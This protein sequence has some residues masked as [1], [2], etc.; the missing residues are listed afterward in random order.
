VG[1][2]RGEAWEHAPW[3]TTDPEVYKALKGFAEENK[4]N[5]TTAEIKLWKCLKNKQLGGQKFRRQHIIDQY[6]ADFVCLDKHLVIEVDGKIHQL[7]EV[8]ENDEIRTQ[9]LNELGFTVLRYTNEEIIANIGN[10]TKKIKEHINRVVT[11]EHPVPPSEGGGRG[12]AFIEVF[13]TRVDTIYGVSFMVLAPEHELVATITTEECKEAVETYQKWAASRSDVERM[14]EVK[15]V[16][17]AFTGSYVVN[18]FNGERVPVYIADYVLAGYGT[19][20]VMGVPSGDQR[21]WNFATHFG[22]PIIPILDGQKDIDKQADNT[23]EGKYINSGIINGME[24]KEATAVLTAWL[25]ERGIGKGKVQHRLRNAV[26]SR[27]RYWGEPVPAYFKNDV[28]YLIDE[29]ELPL[30]LPEIDNYLPTEA[31]D[32]PLGRA[33]NWTYPLSSHNATP[34]PL[35]GAGGRLELSTMPGWAGSSWYWYRYMDAHNDQEFASKEAI[36]YWQAIDL[37]AGGSEHATGHLLYSRFWN[38]FLYDLGKVPHREFAKKLINQGMIQ[39]RSNFVYRVKNTETPTFVSYNLKKDYDVTP[40]H[41]DVNIVTNDVL[42]LEKFKT[43]RLDIGDNPQ[44]I[45]E[46]GGKYVCGWEVEKMSKS[47][48]NV[49]NPDD[50]IEKYGADCFR[51]FEMFLG[52]IEQAKPWDTNGISGVSSFLRKLWALFYDPLTSANLVTDG[53]PTK[54]ELKVLHAAIKKVNEDI[55]RYSLNTCVSTFMICVNELRRLNCNKALILKELVVLI[56]PFAPYV[57]EE[58]WQNALG[59]TT[60]V[61]H[62]TY[63]IANESYLVEDSITYPISI[64]GKKRDL[65]DFPAEANQ[66]EIE[67]AVMSNEK[68]QKYLEGQAVKKVIFVKGKMVNIVV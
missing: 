26:F 49:V 58:L 42:D 55:Q 14:S 53:E 67:A 54:D 37:Y 30:V 41:V 65:I 40:L 39:G 6:I 23:K 5:E 31:G 47:K 4:I 2:G 32:P 8:A 57:A 11:I 22:L 62:D 68:I 63:P 56:A 10:V 45:L 27:Q 60:T 61:H 12:E 29:S 59:N 43:S 64:N 21:D 35:E 34:P 19:G 17:G 33:K 38:H 9:R 15:R 44:F 48:F 66:A 25:E 13:T 36:D 18:P 24:Y 50:M 20:A 3:E 28:P 46:E 51:M 1:G 7:L 52:P 16:S